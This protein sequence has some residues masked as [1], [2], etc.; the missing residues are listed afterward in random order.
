[1]RVNTAGFTSTI[2]FLMVLS[3]APLAEGATVQRP[4]GIT[5]PVECLADPYTVSWEPSLTPGVTYQLQ[6]A[7]DARFVHRRRTVYRGRNTSVDLS[8]RVNGRKY[9][10]RVRATRVNFVASRWVRAANAVQM[11]K[12][13]QPPSA[14]V[15]PATS[16]TGAYQVSWQA[17]PTSGVTY[18]VEE[19]TDAEF[20]T[21]LRTAYTGTLLKASIVGREFDVT[22][23]YRVRANRTN[24]TPSVWVVGANGCLVA[25]PDL[26]VPG[27]VTDFTATPV[28]SHV[29]LSWVNPGDADLAGVKVLRRKDRFPAS[30]SDGI[31]ACDVPGQACTDW[32]LAS[33]TYYYAAFA[34]D[35]AHNFSAA[36]P[37]P[38][39]VVIVIVTP[40]TCEGCHNGNPEYPLAPNVIDGA[41]PG[42][43]GLSYNWYGTNGAKQDG[44]HGD[45]EG[46]DAGSAVPGCTDCHDLTLPPGLHLN[47]V[48]ESVLSG[49]AGNANTAHLKAEF[50]T[51]Y[52]ANGAG[53]WSIQVA[54]DNYCAKQCHVAR[55]V[56]DMRHENPND[57]PP[58]AANHF[59]VE[60]GTH[61][62]V[63]D[64]AAQQ[65][66]KT[67]PIDKHLNSGAAGLPDYAPCVSCHDP[68][69]TTLVEPSKR[70]NFMVRDKFNGSST[71]C[72]AC[73]L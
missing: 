17:S 64:G 6:E 26:T 44:G 20:T 36:A 40:T 12:P 63:A 58:G 19:A 60:F 13:A 54:F 30:A 1:M 5:V 72:L 25:V 52:P 22:Y 3:V 53:A 67:Y 69:G 2:A 46:R 51:K 68:H 15:V 42:S 39:P 11:K 50:F 7:T 8:G 31:V 4:A 29:D 28:A 47:G 49:G 66:G 71:F 37:A 9:F 45:P 27:P 62:T 33:G 70:S 10:Y 21:G 34:Y 61:L 55:S 59:S 18:E 43:S 23:Y 57:T 73:H 24:W 48:L 35:G 65:Y 56:P 38:A 41:L 16:A 14:L 32:G